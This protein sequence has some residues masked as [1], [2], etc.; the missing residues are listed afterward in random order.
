MINIYQVY[1]TVYVSFL[2]KRLNFLRYPHNRQHLYPIFRG[3]KT[4]L[5]IFKGK[6][7]Y[8]VG[9]VLIMR[10]RVFRQNFP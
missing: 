7:V 8:P 2:L 6:S 10:A 3:T 4:D 9:V 1:V 5:H